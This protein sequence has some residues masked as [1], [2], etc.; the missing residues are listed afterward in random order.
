MGKRGSV[1]STR[2]IEEGRK[3]AK[4]SLLTAFNIA[5]A[6]GLNYPSVDNAV[7]ADGSTLFTACSDMYSSALL[8]LICIK[9]GSLDVQQ[10]VATT[11]MFLAQP[12]SRNRPR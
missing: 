8:S 11:T 3:R 2:E 10:L 7:N 4:R 12:P 9:I 5:Q 6:E 1:N